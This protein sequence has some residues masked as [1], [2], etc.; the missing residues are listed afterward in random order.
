MGLVRRPRVVRTL[1]F[2][3]M[4]LIEITATV[5][6]WVDGFMGEMASDEIRF[7]YGGKVWLRTANGTWVRDCDAETISLLVGLMKSKESKTQ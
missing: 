3:L 2:V 6:D 4:A 1:A 5:D 7:T